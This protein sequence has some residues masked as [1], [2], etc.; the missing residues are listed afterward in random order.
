MAKIQNIYLLSEILFT[1]DKSE[2][3]AGIYQSISKNILRIIKKLV[4]QG[5]IRPGTALLGQLV[6]NSLST[7]SLENGRKELNA[8]ITIQEGWVFIGPLKLFKIPKIKWY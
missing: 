1:A 3:I 2:D 8:P 7:N 6:L 4:K 5:V